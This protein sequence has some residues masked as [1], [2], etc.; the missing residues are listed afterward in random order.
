MTMAMRYAGAAVCATL[1]LGGCGVRPGKL[2]SVWTQP[3]KVATTENGLERVALYKW[4][5]T[6]LAWQPLTGGTAGSFELN[7]A[8]RLWSEGRQFS[9][10]PV[11]AQPYPAPGQGSDNAAMCGTSGYDHYFSISMAAD[12]LSYSRKPVGDGAWS[13]AET[14]IKTF[15]RKRFVAL[16]QD[17]TVH[18]CWLDRRH[19]KK[20]LNP[21]YP[22][23]GNYEVAY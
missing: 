22:N 21:V 6:I 16:G 12:A 1:A 18:L 15:T 2:D 4:H 5:G 20:T 17:D 13:A 9:G 23:R 19:E 14:I 7:P 3:V 10:L 8:D 11:D